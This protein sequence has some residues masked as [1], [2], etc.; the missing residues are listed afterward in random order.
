VRA[1]A[2]GNKATRIDPSGL[3]NDSSTRRFLAC[4]FEISSF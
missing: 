4:A 2:L 3:Y 1:I